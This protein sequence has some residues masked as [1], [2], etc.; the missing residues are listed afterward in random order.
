M[1]PQVAPRDGGTCGLGGIQKLTLDKGLCG[2]M[3][4]F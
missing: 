2:I 4:S 1:L 3:S